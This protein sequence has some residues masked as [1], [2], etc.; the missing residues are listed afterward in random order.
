MSELDIEQPEQLIAWLRDTRRIGVDETPVIRV[1]GGGVSNRTVLVRRQK[2]ESWVLKQ[3]LEK[4]RVA[5]EWKCNPERATREALGMRWLTTLAPSGTIPRLVF[6]DPRVHVL[7]MRAVPEP[8]ANWKSVLLAGDVQADHVRQFGQLLGAIHR[9]SRMAARTLASVFAGREFFE[10]LRVEPFYEYTATQVPEAAGF[11]RSL[12]ALARLPGTS[13]VHG[14]YSPKNILV[15]RGTLWLVDHEVVH[16]GDP[17][18]DVG[19]A[20]AHLVAKAHA[21]PAYREA[22]GGAALLFWEH[23]RFATCDCLAGGPEESRAV[24]HALGCLLARVAGRSQVEYLDPAAKRRQSLIIAELITDPP[25][26]VAAL[27]DQFFRSVQRRE[28]NPHADDHPPR[29]A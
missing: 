28:S 26:T 21:L 10:V 12:A 9:Q 27:V 25:D 4:L 2:G 13:L 7:A 8:H 18:F 23:Y 6:E 24:R 11:L 17:M 20:L 14:D 5:V 16:W 15:H 29:S 1:L 19:F 22:L 3:A